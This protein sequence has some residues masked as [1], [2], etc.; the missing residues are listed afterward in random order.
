MIFWRGFDRLNTKCMPTPEKIQIE[1]TESS[2]RV[3]PD[4]LEIV[5]SCPESVALLR[6]LKQNRLSDRRIRDL[7]RQIGGAQVKAIIL[8]AG[9]GRRLNPLTQELPKCLAISFNQKPLLQQQLETLADCGMTRVVVVRGYQAERIQFPGI[10]YYDNPDFAQTNML[11]SLFCAEAELDG[12][13]LISYSDIWYEAPVVERLLRCEK[14]IALGVD[15]DW[16]EYYLGRK[17]HPIQEAENVVFNSDGEVIKI[18]KI[19]AEP[20]EVHGE[21]IGMMKLTRR[22]CELLK[23]H[24]HKAQALDRGGAFQRA[25]SLREAYLTD[26]LQEMADAGVPIHCEIIGSGWKEIDTVEDLQKAVAVFGANWPPKRS[27]LLPE[28]DGT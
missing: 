20:E 21:F 12:D 24:Y 9:M 14:D 18:G 26:L 13:L 27:R 6:A 22:G 5:Q 23:H 10:R 17:E 8:A 4:V 3:P 2:G 1:T 11:H 16:K 7:I 28:R 19:A 15:I 25:P